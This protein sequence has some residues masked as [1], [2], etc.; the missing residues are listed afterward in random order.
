MKTDDTAGF[1]VFKDDRPDLD[2]HE[3]RHGFLK[4]APPTLF[5][6]ITKN[7]VEEM[8]KVSVGQTKVGQTPTIQMTK[9]VLGRYTNAS[10][11]A[12]S[13]NGGAPEAV[14]D[15]LGEDIHD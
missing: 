3:A 2:Q 5:E 14:S 9:A 15:F 13:F 4:S 6:S 8:K 7:E 11:G 12:L 1:F 10:T